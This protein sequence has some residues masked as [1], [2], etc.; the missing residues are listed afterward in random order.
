MHR[1]SKPAN[2]A[3]WNNLMW[4]GASMALAFFVWFIAALQSNPVQERVFRTV[5]IQIDH[6]PDLIVTDQSRDTA[7]VTVRAPE[8]VINQLVPDDIA[9]L[10]DISAE[11]PGT[12]RVNLVPQVSRRAS[13]DTS[14]RQITVTL[15]E[16]R[17][18]LVPVEVTVVQEPPRG[19]DILGAPRTDIRQA[20]V[21]GPLSMVQQVASARVTLNLSAQRSTLEGS[22]ALIAVDAAGNPVS[23]V[24]LEPNITGV[25]V[26]IGL[27]PGTREL[28]VIPN[29][30]DETLP[31]GY[32]FTGITYDPQ[33]VL[34]SGPQDVLDNMPGALSTE[35]IDLTGQTGNFRVDAAV[36]IPYDGIFIVGNSLITVDVGITALST[37]RQFDHVPVRIVGLA[38]DFN[39]VL[40]P[41]EVTVLI[42]GPRVEL[43]PLTS[44]ALSAVVNLN[45][46]QPGTYRV[47]PDVSIL[48]GQ[49]AAASVLVLPEEIDVVITAP[50]TPSPAAP[51]G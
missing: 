19:F 41:E 29:L 30:L 1:A 31:D 50:S 6:S 8:T 16:L 46:L 32:A 27:R 12:Y 22:Y 5:P 33:F 38:S 51:G 18:Q 13:A 42:T 9:V 45:G 49:L 36:R 47:K 28:R 40:A 25:A 44:E 39:A 4:L 15:E 21:S 24:V 34:V 48:Q 20:L 2:S 35:P 26:E 11:G 14:P 17:E 23:D 3:L 43:D 10:A 37:S 7:T